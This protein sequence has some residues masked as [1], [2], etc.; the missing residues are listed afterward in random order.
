MTWKALLNKMYY[1]YYYYYNVKFSLAIL[2]LIKSRINL[3][4]RK[5]NFSSTLTDNGS[6]GAAVVAND[7][8]SIIIDHD[9]IDHWLYRAHSIEIVRSKY[10]YFSIALLLYLG[11]RFEFCQFVQDLYHKGKHLGCVASQTIGASMSACLC[12]CLCL[13]I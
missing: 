13:C 1:Y 4:Q 3:Y 10:E 9:Y 8:A 11:K 7:R 2:S 6:R 5:H 12:L